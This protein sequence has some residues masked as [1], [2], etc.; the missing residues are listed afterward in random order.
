[1]DLSSIHVIGARMS[2]MIQ[3]LNMLNMLIVIASKMPNRNRNVNYY[4]IA[5]ALG[6]ADAMLTVGIMTLKG[7]GAKA[8]KEKAISYIRMSADKGNPAAIEIING[9][10]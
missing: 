3:I 2:L 4:K 9:I 6:N 1:M 7:E 8:D 5:S 10:S